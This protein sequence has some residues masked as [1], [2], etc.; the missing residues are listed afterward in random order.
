[1]GKFLKNYYSNFLSPI[2]HP[3]NVYVRSIDNDRSLSSVTALI[4]AMYP[5]LS[6]STVLQ[7]SSK[8]DWVPIPIHTTDMASDTVKI[9]IFT[10]I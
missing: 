1:M 6:N 9:F 5:D 3:K 8:S 7:W 2:Y 10:Y 4:Y